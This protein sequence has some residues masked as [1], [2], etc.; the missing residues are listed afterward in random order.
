MD[1]KFVSR[2]NPFYVPFSAGRRTCPGEKLALA[3]I[4]FV[5]ARFMQQVKG[6]EMCLPEGADPEKLLYGDPYKSGNWMPFPFKLIL[7]EI[8][9]S[10]QLFKTDSEIDEEISVPHV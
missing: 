5:I 2:P 7:K 10:E 8:K 3:D 4:F 9:D 1:G 6:F